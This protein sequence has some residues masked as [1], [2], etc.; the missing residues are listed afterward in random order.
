MTTE[1][2]LMSVVEKI[3]NGVMV[4]AELIAGR[5]ISPMLNEI[6]SP[7]SYGK[8]PPLPVAPEVEFET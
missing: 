4:L 1:V 7:A 8:V 5:V 2:S 6:I 3:S